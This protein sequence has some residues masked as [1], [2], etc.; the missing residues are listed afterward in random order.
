MC[1]ISHQPFAGKDAMTPDY[2]PVRGHEG[3]RGRGGGRKWR[4]GRCQWHCGCELWMR[5]WMVNGGRA[6]RAVAE[7]EDHFSFLSVFFFFFCC[8]LTM[9]MGCV[10]KAS[11]FF[12]MAKSGRLELW[13]ILWVREAS[14][15]VAQECPRPPKQLRLVCPESELKTWPSAGF[16]SCTLAECPKEGEDDGSS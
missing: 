3:R 1:G 7:M 9:T 14:L 16:N 11:L 5:M 13:A 2:L 8:C 12:S 4:S 15:S 6:M 10:V